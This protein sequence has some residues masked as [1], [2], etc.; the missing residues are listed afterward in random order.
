MLQSLQSRRGEL[1]LRSQARDTQRAVL[2]AA[3]LK[4]DAKITALGSLKDE[5]TGLVGQADAKADAE[6]ARLVTVYS[7]MKPADAA[8]VITQLDDRVRVP[9]AGKMKER[10]LAAILGKMPPNEAKKLTEKLAARYSTTGVADKIA[11]AE[12]APAAPSAAMPKAAAPAGPAPR[13]H[14][15]RPKPKAKPDAKSGPKAA[16]APSATAPRAPAAPLAPGKVN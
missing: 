2:A 4:V 6:L 13:R 8:A 11:Q 15:A 10:T 12:A 9:V 14:A 7:A 16:A 5:L 1:D 3:E